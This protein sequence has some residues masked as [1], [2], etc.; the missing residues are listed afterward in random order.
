MRRGLKTCSISMLILAVVMT[1]LPVNM[2][3]VNAAENRGFTWTYDES[4]ATLT[5]TGE[6][7]GLDDL[8]NKVHTVR[9][10]VKNLT[11][12]QGDII[13]L[14]AQWTEIPEEMGQGEELNS[15]IEE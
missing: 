4:S 12:T 15:D 5:V 8:R 14:Y 9:E 3:T 7:S 10:N 2:L 1:A 11:S 6:D 13:Y